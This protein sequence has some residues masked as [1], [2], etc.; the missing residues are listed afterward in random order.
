M[1]AFADR[2][3]GDRA[4]PAAA[5]LLVQIGIIGMFLWGLG[6]ELR[7]AVEAPLRVFEILIQPPPRRL[8]TPPRHRETDE[9]RRRQAPRDDGGSSPP[10]LRAQATPIAAPVPL[11][12]LPPVSPMAAATLPAAGAEASSGAAEM[13]GPGTGSGGEGSSSGSGRGG[14][15]GGGGYGRL[16]PPRWIRGSL[17]DADYPAGVGEAGGGGTVEVIFRV[18]VNGRVADCR[19][20]QSSGNAELDARTCSLIERRYVYEPSRDETGRPVASRIVET[21]SWQIEDLPPEDE[22]SRRRRSSSRP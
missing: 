19:I 2:K 22:A 18:L 15:G 13:R 7:G 11:I 1:A 5:A 4:G 16:R 17:S 12:P 6:P 3:L 21:H 10:N 20:T 8:E 14:G 9:P